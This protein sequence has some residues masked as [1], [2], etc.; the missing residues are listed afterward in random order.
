VDRYRRRGV[1]AVAV[2]IVA[3]L[4]G[5]VAARMHST[6]SRPAASVAP[7]GVGGISAEEL[8]QRGIY[9]GPPGRLPSSIPTAAVP[10][11]VG[12]TILDPNGAPITSPLPPPTPTPAR[13]TTDG[14]AHIDGDRALTIALANA[15]GFTDPPQTGAPVLVE[16]DD[17][18]S[19]T[20]ATAWVV[21]MTGRLPISAG[22]APTG[23]GAPPTSVDRPPQATVLVFVDAVT[24]QFLEAPAFAPEPRGLLRPDPGRA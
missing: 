23:P 11:P 18:Y 4:V 8:T 19:G 3:A 6:S 10:P 16:L 21:P 24:G 9:L 1:W 17:I 20:V 12:T 13:R 15:A 2:V 14:T 7:M 22:G 5:F